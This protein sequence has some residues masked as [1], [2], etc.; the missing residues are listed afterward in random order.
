LHAP[1]VGGRDTGVL[2]ED[3]D[4]PIASDPPVAETLG[5]PAVP[6]GGAGVPALAPKGTRRPLAPAGPVAD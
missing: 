6:P 4:P 3:T 2:R 1:D 5:G